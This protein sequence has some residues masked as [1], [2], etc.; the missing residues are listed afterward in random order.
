MQQMQIER[1]AMIRRDVLRAADSVKVA[2][3]IKGSLLESVIRSAG[4]EL[5]DSRHLM[6]L[7]VDLVNAGLLTTR[8]LRYRTSERITL[9]NTV[10][11][12]TD[13]GTSI[14][15][16]AIRHPLVMDDRIVR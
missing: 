6:S 14:L 10:Y 2:G 16:G 11:Q 3:G 5:E 8:D 13:E 15:A 1:D 7:C 4:G 12:I 9:D